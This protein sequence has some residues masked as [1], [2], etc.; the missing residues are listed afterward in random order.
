M[1]G[2]QAIRRKKTMVK[3]GSWSVKF[4]LYLDDKGEV[5]FDDLSE[6]TQEHIAEMIK[7]GYTSGEICEWEED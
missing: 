1:D 4:E 2:R 7:Q 3:Y 6:T 5:D